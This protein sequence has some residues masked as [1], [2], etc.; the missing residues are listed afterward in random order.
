MIIA[1]RR[2]LDALTYLIAIALIVV[3]GGVLIFGCTALTII[4][5][6]FDPI[7]GVLSVIGWLAVGN[8]AFGRW[9]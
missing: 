4:A 6:G 1:F 9:I 7:F 8:A 3:F 2:A 5:W